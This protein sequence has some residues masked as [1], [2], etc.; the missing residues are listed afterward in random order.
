MFA[1]GTH[2]ELG[3]IAELL[4]AE[5]QAETPLQ[6][7]MTRLSRLIMVVVL[8]SCALVFVLGLATGG[9]ARELLMAAVALAVAAVP[10]G[11]PIVLT[12]A[13]ALGVTRMARRNAIV[14]WLPAVETL[15]SAT[16]IG[17]DK[18]GTLTE[19]R[20]TVRR[21]WAAGL[22]QMPA[23]IPVRSGGGPALPSPLAEEA[24]ALTLL[25]GV[26]TNEAVVHATADGVEGRGDPTE[27]ALLLAAAEAGLAPEPQRDAYALIAD[28]PFEPSRRFSAALRQWGDA[29]VLFAKGAPERVLD[30]CDALLANGGE[31]PLDV[32]E[33]HTAAHS[34]AADGLRVLAL[35]VSRP[36]QHGDPPLDLE[37]PRG[38][39]LAGLVGLMDPPRKGVREAVTVCHDAGV[40]VVMITGDHALT[41][42]SIATELGITSSS[43]RAVTGSDLEAMDE[44]ELRSAVS[45]TSV[46]A[47]ISPEGKLR[48]V[49][50]LQAQGEVVAVTGDGVNDAPALKS[51]SIGVAMGKGGTDVAREAAEI[52]LTDDNF[53]SIVGAIEQGRITFDNVRRAT[54]FLLSTS[55]ATII[56][57]LVTVAAGWPLL[58]VPAQLLWLNLVTSGLQ[59]VAL[60]FERG[61]RNVLRKPP[62]STRE[63][64]M[65][66][67]LWQRT[68]S[69]SVVRAGGTLALFYWALEST[70]SITTA[71]TVALTT[72]VLFS[73]F[74]AGNARS[75]H[76]SVLTVPL[77][78]NPFLVWATIA[79]LVL[80]LA[81]L[82]FP[83]T[84]LVLR[85]EPLPLH[86]W[87][88]MIA[89]AATVLV[90][91]EAEKAIRR[92]LTRS[93]APSPSG[94]SDPGSGRGA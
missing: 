66:P 63:G 91:V 62:R 69:T 47:R 26:L 22:V 92:R 56:A 48:I 11:L 5:P 4:R 76:R 75:E 52:V 14:R 16:V 44:D 36:R 13:L 51:A 88:I 41:A 1:T 87:P 80:H 32:A 20:M 24:A 35:A 27:I 40:R 29:E 59:D 89:V 70:D 53:V 72:M 77:R 50:V 83:L 2:T 82:Y 15:G 81:A 9:Q 33:M 54:F 34:M 79:N 17:S 30:M 73:A 45:G 38:L 21:I 10:E 64:I 43:N 60:A 84:Q 65:S 58:M 46:F 90:V 19:N 23:S 55:M 93:A 31:V 68:V 67:L 57:L 94:T 3:G 12:I 85:V 6:Q 78:D 25:T 37:E 7:R 39:V 28:L 42:A 49:R 61:D 8:S 86:Y 18:T 71:Q 74:Q